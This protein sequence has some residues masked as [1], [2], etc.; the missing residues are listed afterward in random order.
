M[1]VLDT[2]DTHFA[3]DGLE[4][5]GAYLLLTWE[6][7]KDLS[8][9]L[10]ALIGEA[11][12]EKVRAPFTP[13]PVVEHNRYSFV[14]DTGRDVTKPYHYPTGVRPEAARPMNETWHPK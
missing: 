7:A 1:E 14:D 12:P 2:E 3:D 9:S 8:R 4:Y 13:A 11:G 5:E 10:I 6:E